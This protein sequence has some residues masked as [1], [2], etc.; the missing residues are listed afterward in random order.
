MLKEY[1]V[2]E[3]ANSRTKLNRT[4]VRSYGSITESQPNE[5][6]HMRQKG[7]IAKLQDLVLISYNRH[8]SCLR[9]LFFALVLGFYVVYF[10]FAVKHDVEQAKALIILTAIAAVLLFYVLIRD[11][12]GDAIY[13][14]FLQ[15]VTATVKGQ[16]H[17]VK[18]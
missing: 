13:K 3:V 2:T 4:R 11:L 10:V 16:W 9:K 1:S 8:Y 7:N 5:L 12:Y 6:P 15:P 14:H 17:W 18:W